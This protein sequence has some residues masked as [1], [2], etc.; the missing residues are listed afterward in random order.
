M[1]NLYD[2][3]KLKKDRP[4]IGVYTTNVGVIVDYVKNDNVYTVEFFDE[5]DET[6][7]KALFEYF[8]PDELELTS[9]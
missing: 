2:I 3:V 9:V 4:D 5:N 8:S 6:I 1:F 7:K